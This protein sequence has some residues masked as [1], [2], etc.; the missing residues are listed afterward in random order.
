[1]GSYD[2]VSTDV[3]NEPNMS[4][5]DPSGC[6]T[7]ILKIFAKK[8]ENIPLLLS[9]NLVELTPASTGILDIYQVTKLVYF[10]RSKHLTSTTFKF[11]RIG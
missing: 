4:Y 1:M 7:K 3:Q 11:F 10:P 9:R 6:L 2:N 8:I 5:F